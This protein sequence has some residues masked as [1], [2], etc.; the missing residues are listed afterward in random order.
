MPKALT[1]LEKKQRALQQKEVVCSPEKKECHLEPH[2][3][4]AVESR[5]KERI[6]LG[7]PRKKLEAKPIEGYHLHWVNDYPGR[8]IEA[9][10]GG[11][12]FVEYSETEIND[13]VTPGNSDLGTR[14]KRQ[15]GKNENGEALFAY[16]MKIEENLWKQDQE[17]L[18]KRN[19][20][21]DEAIRRGDLNPVDN[22][23]GSVKL[24]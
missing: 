2:E 8:V 11:Y 9:L 17:E 4:K 20:K 24:S 23:Y 3:K 7:V 10:A 22:Q 18:Q 6:P 5:R 14:V 13:F 1:A 21:V 19:N 16:L 12:Q 15:V